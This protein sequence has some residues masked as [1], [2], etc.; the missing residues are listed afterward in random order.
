MSTYAELLAELSP[1]RQAAFRRATIAEERI[2]NAHNT[3]TSDGLVCRCGRS[4]TTAQ[5]MGLHLAAMRRKA[6]RFFDMELAA[7][8]ATEAVR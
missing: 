2:L 7:P 4:F 3:F 5:G 6:N 1:E 8:A